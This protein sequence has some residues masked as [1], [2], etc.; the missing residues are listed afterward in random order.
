[1]IGSMLAASYCTRWESFMFF[2]AICFPFG[3]GIAYYTP[4]I[5]GWEFF[6]KN[7]GLISG[8]IIGGFGFGAFIFGFVTTA[9]VNPNDEKPDK[10]TKY[11][12][13]DV[14]DKAPGMLRFCIAIWAGLCVL[15]IATVSRSP[16]H[17]KKADRNS[18]IDNHIQ[19]QTG[20]STRKTDK[21]VNADDEEFTLLDA[22]KTRQFWHMF[23]MLLLGMF[24]PLYI[25]SAYKF[26]AQDTLK[27]HVLTVAGSI[28]SVFNGSSRI[29]WATL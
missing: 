16:A 18:I 1:M 26:L 8:I 2:Y 14:A 24:Y 7:K 15:A 12:S 25:A 20:D 13:R 19:R 4:I 23:F 17:T 28:G 11:F 10:E 22:M 9:L 6:P 5:C 27:D 29:F 21:S 3:I